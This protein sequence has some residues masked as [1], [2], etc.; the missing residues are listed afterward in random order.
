MSAEKRGGS[1]RRELLTA[2][3]AFA[4]MGLAA[5]GTGGA[6]FRYMFPVVSYGTPLKFQV[7]VDDLPE[8]G[9]EVIFSEMKTVLRRQS[10]TEVAA[11]SLVCTHLGCTVNRVETGFLC[12]CHGSQYDSDGIVVGGPAPK[13][14]PWLDIRKVPGGKIE[15][16]TGSKLPEHSFFKVV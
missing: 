13:T 12:P 3:S 8:T 14:L 2:G 6:L 7:P 16:D 15:I 9:D 5:A 10:E 4:V 11:I 1:N